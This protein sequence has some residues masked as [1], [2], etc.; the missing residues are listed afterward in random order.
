MFF[1]VYL[2]WSVST[3][4]VAS[5]DEPSRK[6]SGLDLEQVVGEGAGIKRRTLTVL[7]ILKLQFISL[8]LAKRRCSYCILDACGNQMDDQRPPGNPH[9]ARFE[10]PLSPRSIVEIGAIHVGH[11]SVLGSEWEEAN[12]AAHLA[13]LFFSSFCMLL[14]TQDANLQMGVI[15]PHL[16]HLSFQS[17]PM[18]PH[19]TPFLFYNR[20]LSELRKDL[21]DLQKS[22]Q[23]SSIDE[24]PQPNPANP[25][26][27]L[28][29][30]QFKMCEGCCPLRR[31][32]CH[33]IGCHSAQV[34]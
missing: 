14:S 24:Q 27:E 18:E 3:V 13:T 2:S 34:S 22:V 33:L 16:H 26:L 10:P 6:F 15:H 23:P 17:W 32:T 9:N 8:E 1:I 29:F 7:A 5:G 20:T 25:S 30:L 28:C 12:C 4:R 19:G 11:R 31:T 21:Q